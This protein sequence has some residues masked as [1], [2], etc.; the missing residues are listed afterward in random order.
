MRG[1]YT[2]RSLRIQP[3]PL[4]QSENRSIDGQTR[5]RTSRRQP[6]GKVLRGGGI[7]VGVGLLVVGMLPSACDDSEEIEITG[8]ALEEVIAAARSAPGGD[9]GIRITG[10]PVGYGGHPLFYING[11]RVSDGQDETDS[12]KTLSAV[13]LADIE[14]NDIEKIKVIRGSKAVELYGPEAKDG[15]ILI[16]LKDSVSNGERSR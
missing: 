4:T 3:R 9:S 5:R 2:E 6:M 15:V 16:T 13:S 10:T 8:P 14:P 7:W 1:L 12:A 11:T